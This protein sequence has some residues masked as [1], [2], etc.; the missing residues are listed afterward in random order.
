L[1]DKGIK[2]PEDISVVGFDDNNYSKMARPS[3]TTIHQSPTQ[4]GVVAVE[5][6]IR[7]LKGEEITDIDISLPVE[8]IIRGTVKKLV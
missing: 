5:Y 6:L 2:V 7:Q 4:K 3:I 8:I 1:W